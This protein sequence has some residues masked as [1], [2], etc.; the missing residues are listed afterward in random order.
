MIFILNG[1]PGSGKDEACLYLAQLGYKH[2]S[3][4]EQLFLDTCKQFNVSLNWF[5]KGYNDRAL[6]ETIVPELELN[7]NQFSRRGAL[8]YTSEQIMKP[9]Y[10]KSY[11][12]DVLANKLIQNCNYCISDGG[13]EDELLS[14]I[15]KIGVNQI[16]LIQLIR[17]GY[18]YSNDSRNYL[19]GNIIQEFILGSTKV[20]PI[21]EIKL[22]FDI[23]TYRVYN[24][25]TKAEFHSVLKKIHE[26][27]T[28]VGNQTS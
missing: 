19:S 1:P 12:G 13:F 18:D 6:K 27:E 11:Y 14:I 2:F 24:N 15:N 8:I 23:R 7:G 10:G 20:Q 4:K 9:V 21:T 17:D 26:K 5:M 22:K 3:F 28:N 25:S 16:I